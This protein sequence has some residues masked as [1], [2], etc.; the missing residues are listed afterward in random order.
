ML[1]SNIIIFITKYKRTITILFFSIILAVFGSIY[2]QTMT[3]QFVVGGHHGANGTGHDELNMPGLKGEDA[4][5]IESKEL[6]IMFRNFE[7]ISRK[8]TN[9]PNGI[10]TITFS[11]DK[12]IMA[13]LASHTIG[14]INR[15]A[16][17]LD[18]K[19]IIQSKT[20]NIL[21]DRR[22]K[23][24]NNIENTPE[25]IVVTQTSIDPEVVIALQTHA[26]EV[27]DLVNRGMVA[28]HEKMAKQNE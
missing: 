21:F 4:T 7:K 26:A 18:P 27:T 6:A 28:A 3:M 25:G 14:M 2:L 15:V 12:K 23:I 1:N 16:E 11:S 19:V 5:D 22:E 8:V 13:V 17:G 20:L 9:L 24:I 10:R